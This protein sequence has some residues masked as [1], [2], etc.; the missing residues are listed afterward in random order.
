MTY[1]DI[2][3]EIHNIRNGKASL[4]KHMGGDPI[5]IFVSE[6]PTALDW[7]CLL[8]KVEL[9]FLVSIYSL[10]SSGSKKKLVIKNPIAGNENHI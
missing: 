10:T 4:K 1:D 3:F 5:L 9:P 6:I 8:K 7:G 2:L